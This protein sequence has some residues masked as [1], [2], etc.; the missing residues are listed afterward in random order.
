MRR[1]RSRRVNH[2]R[3]KSTSRAAINHPNVSDLRLRHA[4]SYRDN[5]KSVIER[6][7][8]PHSFPPK[9]VRKPPK[10]KSARVP[11]LRELQAPLEA[12]KRRVD[13]QRQE[14]R[15]ALRKIRRS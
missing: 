9:A 8:R 2:D 13:D 1:K 12:A 3:S 14:H 7:F 10:E 11:S 4:P 5:Y 6:F 15:R